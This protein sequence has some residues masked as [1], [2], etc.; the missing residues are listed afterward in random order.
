M[1]R[2]ALA[3]PL[4]LVLCFSAAAQD[5]DKDGIPD[6]VETALG[7][8]PD[9][10]EEFQLI[11]DD[12]SKADGDK[13]LG[14]KF[15]AAPDVTQAAL[16]NVARDRWLLR[17]E[18]SKPYVR[19]PN[20]FILYLDVDGDLTTGRQDKAANRGTDLMY[21]QQDGRFSL[22]EHTKGLRTGP[23]RMEVVDR[24]IYICDDVKFAERGGRAKVRFNV[25]SH[26]SPPNASDADHSDWRVVTAPAARDADKPRIGPP[27]PLAPRAKLTTDKPDADRDGVPDETELVL[28]TSPTVPEEF[29]LIKDDKAQGQGDKDIRNLKIAPDIT[30]VYFA[31][32]AG[33]RYVWRIDFAKDFVAKGTVLIFYLDCDNRLDTG[34]QDGALG[35]DVMLTC[36]NGLFS[37]SIRNAAAATLDR[38]ERGVI[39]GNVVYFSMDLHLHQNR[40]GGSEYRAMVLSHRR[41]E[42]ADADVTDWFLVHGPGESDRP[43]PRAG[44]LS[45]F[46]S[47]GFVVEKPWLG[48]R[49]DLRQAQTLTIE[50]SVCEVTGF[51]RKDRAFV[52][53]GDSG[54]VR[55]KAP[56]SGRWHVGLVVTD[57]STATEHIEVRVGR[58]SAGTAVAAQNDGE[59][60]IFV[61]RNAA[62]LEPGAQVELAATQLTRES[63]IS[64]IFLAAKPPRPRGLEIADL[65]IYCPRQRGARVDVHVCWT[66]N[67]PCSGTVR[68]GMG[69]LGGVPV[70]SGGPLCSMQEDQAGHNHRVILRGLERGKRYRVQAFVG[71]GREASESKVLSFVAEPKRVSKGQARRER[72]QLRVAEPTAG[73]RPLW[74][75]SSGVPIPAGALAS[76]SQCRLLDSAG[77]PAP[78]GFR[79]LS[80]WPDGSVKWLLVSAATALAKGGEATYTLEY[81]QDV[82]TPQVEKPVRVEKTGGGLRITNGPLQVTLS[83]A[84]FAPPGRVAFDRNRDGVFQADEL[85]LA[86]TGKGVVLRDE[87]GRELTTSGARCTRLEAEEEGTVRTVVLAEG[88][89]VGPEGRRLFRYACRLY[90]YRGFPGV[91]MAFTL[92]NNEGTRT[93]PPTLTRITSLTWPLRPM[94]G[95]IRMAHGPTGEH[96]D[97][98]VPLRV[99]QD[100]D[101]R[102]VVT[103]GADRRESDLRPVGNAGLVGER[104]SFAL[105]LRY[106][107][108]TYPKAMSIEPG[109]VT[110]ELLPELSKGQYAKHSTIA[111]RTQRYFWCDA[112]KYLLPRGTAISHDMLAYFGDE[113]ASE[114]GQWWEREPF[115]TASPEHYCKSKAFMEISPERADVFPSWAAF[116]GRGFSRQAGSRERQREYDFFSFGDWYGE[117]RYNWGNLEYDMAWGLLVHFA[118]TADLRFLA[119][120][121][122]AS[123]HMA[124]IDVINDAASPY[125]LGRVHVHCLAHTGGYHP[126][127]IEGAEYW[128]NHGGHDVG[129][130]WTQG[131]YTTYCLTGDRRCLDSAELVATWLATHYTQAF[132]RWV[133]RNYGWA[134]LAVLGGYHTTGNPYYLNAARMFTEYTLAKQDPG[135]GHWPHPI[136]E[137]THSPKCMGGKAFMTGVGLTALKMMDQI[138][139]DEDVK[140]AIVRGCDWLRHR[141]WHPWDNS[142]QY[143]ECSNFDKSS[144]HAGTYMLCGALAYAHNLCPKPEFKQMLLLSLGDMIRRGPSGS[145]K[146]YAMQIRMVPYALH[147]MEKWG[148]N[149]VPVPPPPAPVVEFGGPV[150]VAPEGAAFAA[151][152]LNRG[153][154]P[155]AAL[156]EVIRASDGL[157]VRPMQVQWQARP[158]R[159]CGPAFRV[160]GKLGKPNGEIK[161]A[162]RA[163]KTQGT[164]TIPCRALAAVPIGKGLGYVGGEG[165]PLG[166]ALSGMKID[167]PALDDVRADALSRFAALIIGCEAHHKNFAHLSDAPWRLTEFVHAGGVVAIV[168]LQDS[169]YQMQYLPYPLDVSNDSSSF[170]AV[171]V[172]DHPIFSRPHQ[173]KSLAGAVSYD[174]IVRADPAWRVLAKDQKGQPS[175]L[176]C[177]F[178]KGRII[179]VQPSPDRYVCGE[180]QPEGALS[181]D[182]CRRLLGNLVAYLRP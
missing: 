49:R 120:A 96:K 98:A 123:R 57:D 179:V 2:S 101:T 133:H 112:G 100:Y 58:R 134:T 131:M 19:V 53:R 171:A 44:V 86:G 116:V 156:A 48:W 28:G 54:R 50:P 139:P 148:E 170:G 159:A 175:V 73:A 26:V 35:T 111:E 93:M 70:H 119:R 157:S 31:N 41:P 103:V 145:G 172:V 80:H 55:F 89:F 17:I 56:R 150:T 107:W 82:T 68:W 124:A 94:L 7:S 130:T 12:K 47:T 30:K 115:L 177:A 126:K 153:Q 59:L 158:G 122:E 37:P 168:Q 152:V 178:G 147:T 102:T 78:A 9:R 23:L 64:E 160:E 40:E 16:A 105:A 74:P 67:W 32:V 136:G 97:V 14:S 87:D 72:V 155:V 29:F 129:H 76:A 110:A 60:Y 125:N 140:H 166:R 164:A 151:I 141:M 108:Q 61:T 118:R 176:E 90:F 81:G 127:R 25:L 24:A 62:Q 10:A 99:L 128:F 4:L 27:P 34:R 114:V 6:A 163:G 146:G 69:D 18:F 91:P 174:T 113:S 20:T 109:T 181:V 169:T 182:E 5:S 180:V 8:D 143:A 154:Q 21:V 66:T 45:E 79:E 121:V 1:P 149:R 46:R 144:T 142:F 106:F 71:Q 95:S 84:R 38:S 104:G 33:N 11:L 92:V 165:D 39:D 162:Y 117:R 65:A 83:A 173:I 75:V 132:Y 63:K 15:K 36:V 13:T 42:T 85:V 135:T 138:D 88:D 52:G 137:C 3:M 77:R 51:E 161:I 167:L 43:K 22:V